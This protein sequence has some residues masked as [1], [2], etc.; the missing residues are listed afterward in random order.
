MR[1]PLSKKI[2]DHQNFAIVSVFLSE[3]MFVFS[4]EDNMW[5]SELEGFAGVN[6]VS[7]LE[8]FVLTTIQLLDN[9][10]GIGAGGGGR[11]GTDKSEIEKLLFWFFAVE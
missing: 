9:R 7:A 1:H 10:G 3:F 11:G 2:W 4:L 6:V 8:P 5:P